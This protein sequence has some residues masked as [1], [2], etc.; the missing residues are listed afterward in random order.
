MVSSEFYFAFAAFVLF[1]GILAFL[2]LLRL[3]ITKYYMNTNI[4]SASDQLTP[5][6][7]LQSIDTNVQGNIFPMDTIFLHINADSEW[8]KQIDI[9]YRVIYK[10]IWGAPFMEFLNYTLTLFFIPGVVTIIPSTKGD[11]S[12]FPVILIISLLIEYKLS[13]YVLNLRFYSLFNI[14]DFVGKALPKWFFHTMTDKTLFILTG[15]RVIFLPL[16]W[17]CIKPR[18]FNHDAFPIIFVVLLSISNGICGSNT[19]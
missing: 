9:S 16:L 10:K 3:P 14:F 17:F 19:D 7:E 8:R 5:T 12:W 13:L 11:W 18:L 4:T 1:L 15:L 2:F 6:I